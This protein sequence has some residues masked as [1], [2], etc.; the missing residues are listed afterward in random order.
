LSR[1][2]AKD[3]RIFGLGRERRGK[4]IAGQ[5]VRPVALVAFLA[6][7]GVILWATGHLIVR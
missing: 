2:G 3:G 4:D 5:E 1:G 6:L 7:V